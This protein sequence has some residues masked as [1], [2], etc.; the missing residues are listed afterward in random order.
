MKQYDLIVIGTGGALIVADAAIKKGL[1]VAIIEKA[2]WGGTCLTRGCI[3]TKV[4]VT[5][6]NAVREIE[7]YHK[8]GIQVD[9]PSIDWDVM[10]KRVWQKIDESKGI[11]TYY[12]A[13]DNVDIYQGAAT[14]LADKV[15]K[16]HLNDG[17]ESEEMT[18]TNI[19]IG[20]GG[21]SKI[22]AIPGLE[23]A[24]YLSSESLFGD[25]Y[26]QKPFKSL[27]IMG[28]G[29]IGTEFGHV[30]NA[31]GTEVHLIQHN[32]RLLP[33]EDVE[34]SEQIYKD[35]SRAGLHIYLNQEPESVRIENGQKVV[36]IRD[37]ATNE[38]MEVR[39]DEIL[40]ASGIVPST[41]ELH[42]ENT[43][44]VTKRGG[45][46]TTNEFLETSVEGVYA[47]G[48][49]NGEA[50]F[51]HKA[52]YEADIIAHNLYRA[53]KDEDMRWARYDLVP[54]V[55]FTYPEVGHIGM[56]EEEAKAAG[57]HVGTGKNYYSSSAKGFALGFNPGDQDDGFVKI[58]VDKD[59][60]HILGVHVIGP[61]ASILFQPY[62]NLLNS[63]D[64]P[65][66]VINEEIASKRTQILR[67]KGL[68]RHMDPHSVITVGE[69]MSPHPALGEIAMWTQVYYEHRW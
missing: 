1:Q 27:I 57:Y 3:P 31:A 60:N 22:N 4:M 38:V 47:M 5:V 43:G 65:L 53:E 56:T 23:E 49:V 39:A 46:I 24:G 8:I 64:T 12:Q 30:F 9:K 42:L 35:L 59:T 52:N 6:A 58:V 18:A 34:I 29:P 37:R 48:D 26:P 10:S 61:Q 66:T 69:T 36:S 62:V 33:K 28:G 50:P 13:F 14:F 68:I 17:S 19:I 2:K 20:T 54:A 67:Q 15:L 25:K 21:H 11:V 44:I 51:R 63:G 55:T 40:M 16:V 32:K 45:W 7:D 41:E